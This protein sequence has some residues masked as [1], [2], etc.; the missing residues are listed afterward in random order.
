MAPAITR[1]DVGGRDVTSYLRLLL[2]RGGYNF[3][4]SA[5]ID[6]VRR[7]KEAVRELVCVCL[8]V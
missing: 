5:G 6:T 3:D 1:V 2:R 8:C 7:I 4:T